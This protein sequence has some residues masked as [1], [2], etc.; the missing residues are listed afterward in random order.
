MQATV[1]WQDILVAGSS[2]ICFGNIL[3]I[4]SLLERVGEGD[5]E[6]LNPGCVPIDSS[7]RG[8]RKHLGLE[9]QQSWPNHS[10]LLNAFVNLFI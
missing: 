9:K 4:S 7:V 10:H 1:K 6:P 2:I 8:W 3:G 5:V